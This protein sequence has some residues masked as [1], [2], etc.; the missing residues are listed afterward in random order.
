M[1]NKHFTEY[2][3][4]DISNGAFDFFSSPIMKK[5]A[6]DILAAASKGNMDEFKLALIEYY[7]SA[8]PYATAIT[9]ERLLTAEQKQLLDENINQWKTQMVDETITQIFKEA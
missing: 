4:D 5:E 2:P 1:H 3:M 8:T 9:I 6:G 7:T